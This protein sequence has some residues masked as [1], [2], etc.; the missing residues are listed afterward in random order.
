MD[1]TT[2]NYYQKSINIFFK[3]KLWVSVCILSCPSHNNCKQVF[4]SIFNTK[5]LVC[6]Y[7]DFDMIFFSLNKHIRQGIIQ[8]MLLSGQMILLRLGTESFFLFHSLPLC[9]STSQSVPEDWRRFL[10]C[11]CLFL[12]TWNWQ[13]DTEQS[14]GRGRRKQGALLKYGP[15]HSGGRGG[16]T[17]S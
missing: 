3:A 10:L 14:L 15:L 11:S 8:L 12:L 16:I 2:K 9:R 1:T 5:I 6:S 17:A 13:T 4:F 7:Y